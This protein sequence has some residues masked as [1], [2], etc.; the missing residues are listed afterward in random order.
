MRPIFQVEM[1]A[2]HKLEIVHKTTKTMDPD[3]TNSIPNIDWV[4][5]PDGKR[6]IFGK[7]ARRWIIRPGALGNRPVY[8]TTGIIIDQ[9]P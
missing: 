3:R 1:L 8:W 5:G 4:G 9:M 2:G 7:V 6:V